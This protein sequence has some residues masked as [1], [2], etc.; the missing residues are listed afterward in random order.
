MIPDYIAGESVYSWVAQYFVQSAYCDRNRFCTQ[1]FRKPY[2]RLH[3]TLP[4]HIEAVARAAGQEPQYLLHMGT[5]FPLYAFALRN[6]NKVQ[7]L[8]AAMLGKGWGMMALSGQAASKLTLGGCLLKFCPACLL[9]DEEKFGVGYWHTAHQF[10]GVT[11]CAEHRLKLQS[12]AASTGG[13]DRQYLLPDSSMLCE[14]PVPSEQEIYLS[15]FIIALYRYLCSQ[16]PIIVPSEYYRLL[17][18]QQGYLTRHGNIRSRK[19]WHD[20]DEFWVDLFSGPTPPLPI[21]LASYRYVPGLVHYNNRSSHYLKHVMLMAF[22]SRSPQAFF[23]ADN[24]SP[25]HVSRSFLETGWPTEQTVLGL[26]REHT[27]M[28][29]IS[30]MTGLSVGCI[31]QLAN[32]HHL[33]VGHRSKFITPEMERSIWRQALMGFK[34]EHIARHHSVSVGTVEANIQSHQGLSAWRRHLVM[35]RRKREHRATLMTYLAHHARGSRNNIKQECGAAFYWLYRH[36]RE[37][38]YL[39]LP[40]SQKTCYHPS[41]DWAQRDQALAVQLG[42]MEVQAKSLSELDRSLGGRGWLIKYKDKLPISHALAERLLAEY[43]K[44]EN[45]NI[46]S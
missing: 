10:C 26:L 46:P 9:E 11:A 44:K 32:R 14:Q 17:L 29:K 34:R 27:S 30:I 28:R 37:W 42:Q 36:D 7:S 23:S 33:P 39:Q 6:K 16:S 13:I 4:A 21:E 3:P 5:A 18:A 24:Q 45:L 43:A 15:S 19:L 8:A 35:V 40:D 2:I 12:I 20:L 1:L 31:K 25:P 41:V 38:L 22:L